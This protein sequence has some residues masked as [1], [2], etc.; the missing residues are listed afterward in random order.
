MGITPFHPFKHQKSFLC[1]K[2]QGP[3][4]AFVHICCANCI[5]WKKILTANKHSELR[6]ETWQVQSQTNSWATYM[7]NIQ[8]VSSDFM[9]NFHLMR[10][11]L[12][13]LESQVICLTQVLLKCR[14]IRLRL[15]SHKIRHMLV[16]WNHH[17]LHPIILFTIIFSLFLTS[18]QWS[19]FVK[20][21]RDAQTH[22]Q[23]QSAVSHKLHQLLNNIWTI[24]FEVFGLLSPWTTQNLVKKFLQNL[25]R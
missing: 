18:V 4:W 7:F 2:N 9:S 12:V 15:A 8:A 20:F 5:L 11:L 6:K 3:N 1:H 21:N 16:N 23:R 19:C 14:V 22:L 25:I 24:K 17:V 13:K 10:C